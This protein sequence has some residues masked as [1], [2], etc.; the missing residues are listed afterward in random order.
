[1]TLGEKIKACRTSKNMTQT[2]LGS[3]CGTSKQTIFKYET[4]VITNIP[5]DKLE[6]IAAALDVSAAYLMGWE[7]PALEEKNDAPELSESAKK[8]LNVILRLTP[9]NQNLLLEVAKGLLQNRQGD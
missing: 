9:E 2:E 7:E 3:A 5:L 4:G 6:A 1:M 8:L